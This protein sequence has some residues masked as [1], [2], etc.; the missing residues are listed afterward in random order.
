[1]LTKLLQRTDWS[2]SLWRK[3]SKAQYQVLTK[4][5]IIFLFKN[6]FERIFK[7]KFRHS[8]PC[9]NF[10][11]AKTDFGHI[12]LLWDLFQHSLREVVLKNYTWILKTLSVHYMILTMT[13]KEP[14]S[15]KPPKSDVMSL[16]KVVLILKPFFLN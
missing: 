10:Y 4:R 9:E 1:M 3:F 13:I 7:S 12:L 2:N 14:S 6:I 8:S 5:K 16:W 15:A 11:F